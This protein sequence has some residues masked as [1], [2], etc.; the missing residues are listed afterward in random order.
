MTRTVYVGREE[1]R[2]RER[3]GGGGCSAKF[4][5]STSPLRTV[6]GNVTALIHECLFPTGE[7]D[8]AFLFLLLFQDG[9]SLVNGT[10]NNQ[11]QQQ[12]Q[13]QLTLILLFGNHCR[14]GQSIQVKKKIIRLS[15]DHCF[16]KL[17]F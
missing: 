11:Q 6:S 10:S 5:Y 7:N 1:E 16:G 8:M 17:L 4:N 14:M 2:E 12:Q 13:Q 15:S 9:C 3:G